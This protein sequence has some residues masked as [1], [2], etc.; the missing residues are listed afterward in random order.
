MAEAEDLPIRFLRDES[1]VVD[2]GGDRF[3]IA[4]IEQVKKR[5]GRLDAALSDGAGDRLP[6]VL[7]AHYPSTVY[8]LD[9]R[10]V[11]LQL[12]GHTHGGQWRFPY[13]GCVWSNDRIRPRYARG[14]H[15]INGTFLHVSAGIGTSPPVR[16]RINCPPEVTVLTLVPRCE[17]RRQVPLSEAVDAAPAE[18]ASTK[19]GLAV[20]GA[21]GGWAGG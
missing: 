9:R 13:V 21:A 2:H 10:R 18:S 11:T 15:A 4:G 7:L 19:R 8:R 12:S 3:C 5:G 1:E 6:L 14:L 20:C 16:M 17:F